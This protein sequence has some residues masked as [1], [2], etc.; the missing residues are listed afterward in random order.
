M[1]NLQVFN[2]DGHELTVVINQDG[3]PMFV[4][5]QVCKMLDI[6]N[7][8]DAISRLEEDEKR[9]S[10]IPTPGGN[11]NVNLVT[12]SGLY[13]LIFRSNKEEAKKFRKWVTSE[14]L[15]T[16]RKTGSFTQKQ[17]SRKEMAL[18]VIEQEER[19]ERLLLESTEKSQ[20]IERVYNE[21]ESANQTIQ[22]QAPKVQYVDQVLDSISTHTTT[23][24][25]KELGMAAITLNKL[26]KAKNIQYFHNGHWVL[27]KKYQ[28]KGYTTT[29]THSYTDTHGK[30]QTNILT[31]WTEKGR[32]FI[33]E[34]FNQNLGQ[35]NN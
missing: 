11:Q 27:M 23:T 5:N 15:P 26:L 6:S 2:F 12:E 28:D 20:V 4:A 22:K 35:I 31:V 25:A 21:L 17:L 24:I 30:Q 34:I 33:H 7:A 1:D 18:M 19:I 32:K 9:V 13:T 16:I 10:E 14:V 29:K 8:R 3:N